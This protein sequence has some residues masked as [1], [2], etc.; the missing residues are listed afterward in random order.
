MAESFQ[1]KVSLLNKLHAWKSYCDKYSFFQNIAIHPVAAGLWRSRRMHLCLLCSIVKK[2]GS[3]LHIYIKTHN[4]SFVVNELYTY[5]WNQGQKLFVLP[6][7]CYKGM[8]LS[9]PMSKK[10]MTYF[11]ND[12]LNESKKES[13]NLYSLCGL[14]FN[15]RYLSK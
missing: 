14:T 9:A 6:L 7:T 15:A 12:K 8:S 1:T 11:F 4:N 3:C 10:E 13:E 5:L 2:I